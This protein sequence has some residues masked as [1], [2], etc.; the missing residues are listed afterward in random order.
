MQNLLKTRDVFG[1][2][3]LLHGD[4]KEY[5]TLYVSSHWL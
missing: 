3:P 4:M 2:T 1:A 5:G